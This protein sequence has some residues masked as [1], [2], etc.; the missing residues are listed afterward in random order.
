[1]QDKPDPDTHEIDNSGVTPQ[2]IINSNSFHTQLQNLTLRLIKMNISL[3]C[4][5]N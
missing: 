1:M 4:K 2:E 3:N 5:G